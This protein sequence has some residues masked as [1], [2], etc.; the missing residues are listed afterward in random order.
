MKR[1]KG[2]NI[3]YLSGI[4]DFDQFT[5]GNDN[6]SK[7]YTINDIKNGYK[8]HAFDNNDIDILL[9]SEWP[10]SY[11]SDNIKN[12]DIEYHSPI[13]QKLINKCKP[14]YHFCAMNNI[15]Y[16]LAPFNYI[17][18]EQEYF[19]KTTHFV[20]LSSIPL[21]SKSFDINKIKQRHELSNAK[22]IY[23][24]RIVPLT[25]L[26]SI[27]RQIL[28]S[29]DTTHEEEE[30]VNISYNNNQRYFPFVKA[31]INNPFSADNI[32]QDKQCRKRKLEHNDDEQDD[33]E[34]AL[35]KRKYSHCK[36]CSITEN[37]I[38]RHLVI[39][40]GK[41]CL[42]L[43]SSSPFSDRIQVNS[44]HFE[45]IPKK[46]IQSMLSIHDSDDMDENIQTEIFKL[47]QCV[48]DYFRP[49]ILFYYEINDGSNS[50]CVANFI[51][52]ISS[53]NDRNR[54]KYIL[55]DID[56]TENIQF[57][58]VEN[59]KIISSM[60][61]QYGYI[62]IAIYLGASNMMRSNIMRYIYN[63]TPAK[64]DVNYKNIVN[65]IIKQLTANNGHETNKQIFTIE[66]EKQY[67]QKIKQLFQKFNPF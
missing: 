24:V 53:Y 58:L 56:K 36:Y 8:V 47:T 49:Q 63:I 2:L 30:R 64:K 13:I 31:L 11:I 67:S 19:Y 51:S 15:Y 21:S 14:Q 10:L 17:E 55:Q 61:T 16:Q 32:N 12:V 35:K 60:V 3:A 18:N 59:D 50:H 5:A 44:N 26:H 9:S 45:L 62:D 42:L 34:I 66:Q 33:D 23:A 41:H 6:N 57:Q 39:C 46:H 43:L 38:S 20:A 4:Y 37:E 22:Y 40:E 65:K 48:S 52:V 27:S 1:I 54:L 29:N 28:K 7:Y 25:K